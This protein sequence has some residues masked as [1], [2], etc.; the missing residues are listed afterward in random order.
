MKIR[1]VGHCCLV[2]EING[3]KMM[4][5]PGNYMTMEQMQEK[6]VGLILITHEH[7]DHFHVD[8]LKELLKNNPNAKVVT[9]RAVGRLLDEVGIKY[10]VLEDKIEKVILGIELE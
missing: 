5:D 10:E 2:I 6:G 9:N 7:V 3:N 4:T 1:K 8:S